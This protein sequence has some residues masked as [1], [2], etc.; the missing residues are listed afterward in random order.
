[1]G[2]KRELL[3]DKGIFNESS[4]SVVFAVFLTPIYVGAGDTKPVKFED[5]VD[6]KV[7]D[8]GSE[9]SRSESRRLDSIRLLLVDGFPTADTLRPNSRVTIYLALSCAME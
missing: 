7:V 4:P 2:R 5:V 3:N 6:A 9:L 8:R 1:M